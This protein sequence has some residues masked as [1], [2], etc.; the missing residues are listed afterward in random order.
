[1]KY[2]FDRMY[3]RSNTNSVKWDN[4]KAVFGSDDVIPMWIAD[5]DFPVCAT[6]CAGAEETRKSTSFM[7]HSGRS[8]RHRSC[9]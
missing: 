8:K 2:N 3:D 6:D 9:C 5:M 7:V 1:M 4:V